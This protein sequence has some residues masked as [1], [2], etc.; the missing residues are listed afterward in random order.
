MATSSKSKVLMSNQVQMTKS[1]WQIFWV[2]DLG[3]DLTFGF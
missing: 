2:L 1:K 3:F